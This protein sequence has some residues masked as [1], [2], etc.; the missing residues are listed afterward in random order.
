MLDPENFRTRPNGLMLRVTWR[1]YWHL[2]FRRDWLRPPVSSQK[3]K[4]ASLPLSVSTPGAI[5]QVWHCFQTAGYV[6]WAAFLI[7]L[8]QL[9]TAVDFLRKG[10]YRYYSTIQVLTFSCWKNPID[11]LWGGWTQ[12]LAPS[13][14]EDQQLQR[15]RKNSD[16]FPL[17][18]LWALPAWGKSV[19]PTIKGKAIVMPK[20][21]AF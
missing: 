17:P 1:S 9:A 5:Q 13:F 4:M 6:S 10:K 15:R 2:A 18:I 20:L 11:V 19:F 7:S 21:L 14:G 12:G 8:K 3:K 16:R